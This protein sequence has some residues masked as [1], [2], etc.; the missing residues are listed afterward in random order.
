MSR[1]ALFLTFRILTGRGIICFV[2]D[3]AW[4]GVGGGEGMRGEAEEMT[5]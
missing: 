3:E 1:Q 2:K 4:N 5:W